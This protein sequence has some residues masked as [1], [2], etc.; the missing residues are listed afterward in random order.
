MDMQKLTAS[1]D[2]SIH[3]KQLP[4]YKSPHD[5]FC[6]TGIC[7]DISWNWQTTEGKDITSQLACSSAAAGTD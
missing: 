2:T 3:A 6:D 7:E 1:K 4:Q 5:S